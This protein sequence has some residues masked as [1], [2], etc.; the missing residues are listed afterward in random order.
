MARIIPVL[1]L[2]LPLAAC[3]GPE[4]AHRTPA[5]SGDDAAT[6][7]AAAPAQR[8][9]SGP[10]DTAHTPAEPGPASPEQPQTVRETGAGALDGHLVQ[11]SAPRRPVDR[12]NYAHF[13]DNPVKRAAEQ[14]VS[15]FSVDVDTGAYANVRRF[16]NDGRLP[17]TDAVRTEELINYFDYKY[18]VPADRERPFGVATAVARTPWNDDTHLVQVGIQG[19]QPTGEPPPANLVFLID[20]SG[21]MRSPDK[22]SL[23]KSAMK[24][25]VKQLDAEDRVSIAVYAGAAGAVL[26][27]TP[28]DRHAQI[29]A[30]IDNLRAGGSTNGG[31]GIHLAYSMAQQAF[32]DDGINRVILAS[33]GDFNVGTADFQTLVDLVAEKR[34]SDVAL[35]TLGFGTGNYNDRLVEQLSNKGNGNYAYID[36]LSEARRVL[37]DNHA[38]TLQTIAKDVKIQI[39]FNPASVAEYRLIGYENRQLAREDFNNDNVDAGEIGAGHTVTALYEIALVGSGGERMDP[40]RYGSGD[41]PAGG[42][43]DELAF[44]RLRYKAPG[45]DTSRLIEQ[46]IERDAIRPLAEAG[47]DLR[48][49]A[50]VAG[51][52]QL[53]RGGQYTGDFGHSEVLELARTAR[54]TDADGRRGEF[55]QLVQLAQALDTFQPEAG[56]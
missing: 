22:L 40:L 41:T 21:S 1:L 43:T 16:L 8:R 7:D 27:P 14:P 52:G 18:A 25:L 54:G 38:A 11:M 32:I 47:D 12:E 56:D 17:R 45:G 5:A 30:A 39:E 28:G 13:D 24:L 6:G 10:Y 34:A 15:T 3:T 23:L 37:V 33:D 50:A 42:D 44:L 35:T 26:E 36:N 2:L 51:F 19:W 46:P 48:F 29:T 4:S 9:E 31:A 53:L 49:A 55:L 20:V